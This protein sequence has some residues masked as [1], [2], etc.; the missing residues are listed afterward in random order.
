MVSLSCRNPVTEKRGRLVCGRRCGIDVRVQEDERSS[1]RFVQKLSPHRG[2]R[3]PAVPAPAA[4]EI[5]RLAQPEVPA[6]GFLED[7]LLVENRRHLRTSVTRVTLDPVQ[8]VLREMR[9]HVPCL[10]AGQA[11]LDA[12]Q[13]GIKCANPANDQ[14]LAMVPTV[15][16]VLGGRVP[17][18]EAHD[19]DLHP[20]S[21][22]VHSLQCKFIA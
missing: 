18:V 13:V 10:R 19:P 20:T 8:L 17:D 14:S 11:L 5:R 7:L 12:E 3:E 9:A 1:R 2:S 22:T 21:L 6:T 15:A 16:L 4:P